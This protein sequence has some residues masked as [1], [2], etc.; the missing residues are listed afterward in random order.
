MP[1]RNPNM[2]PVDPQ[3]QVRPVG[4]VIRNNLLDTPDARRRLGVQQIEPTRVSEPVAVDRAFT[5][6][7]VLND[8]SSLQERIA[9]QTEGNVEDVAVAALTQDF[10]MQDLDHFGALDRE[11]FDNLTPLERHQTI[12]RLKQRV[13]W[14]KATTRNVAA[15]VIYGLAGDNI[16]NASVDEFDGWRR[17]HLSD[18][19]IGEIIAQQTNQT[20][21]GMRDDV[22]QFM[23]SQ[24]YV[25]LGHAFLSVAPELAPL[26][27]IIAKIGLSRSML[28]SIDIKPQAGWK[29]WAHGPIKQQIREHLVALGPERAKHAVTQMLNGLAELEDG[30]V[31]FLMT[32]YSTREMIDG[33]F[34]SGVLSGFDSAN[35]WDELMSNIELGLESVFSVF[36]GFKAV[37]KLTTA[38]FDAAK[39]VTAFTASK[40]AGDQRTA[41]QILDVIQNDSIASKFGLLPD[42][43]VPTLLPRP[44]IDFVDNMPE[45]TE[46]TKDLVLRLDRQRS[47]ILEVSDAYTGAGLNTADKANVV[48]ETIRKMDI[49]D[50]STIQPRMSTIRMFDNETGFQVTAVIGETAEHGYKTI[51]D[52]AAA[53]LKKD[54]M[55]EHTEIVRVGASGTLEPVFKDGAEFFRAVASGKF[56]ASAAPNPP[57]RQDF[58]IRYTQ[59]R[60]WNQADK[61]TFEA[62]TLQN[63]AKDINGYFIPPNWKFGTEIYGSFLKQYMQEQHLVT[64]FEFL[65]KPFYKLGQ[66]DKRVVANLM[67]WGEDFSKDMITKGEVGRAPTLKEMMNEFTNVTPK[68]LEGYIALRRGYDTMHDM[69]QAGHQKYISALFPIIIQPSTL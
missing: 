24:A 34:T 31:G 49:S 21:R 65:F 40:A 23:E 4:G 28:E 9:T 57:F 59:D 42:Q 20:R 43:A 58:F 56:P 17:E 26:Y 67:E 66:K 30:P 25:N 61:L 41:N 45:L 54:P 69:I 50:G 62:K 35:D 38:G 29:G 36:I 52:V 5:E 13:D 37:G 27:P 1:E 18:F 63:A 64:N 68:Q 39:G 22:D 15:Y 47:E 46:G 10:I 55:L 53:V 8:P 2:I 48:T 12:N 6:T 3:N 16:R 7:M 32:K 44:H 19:Q 60:F 14:R 11:T 33:I 51:E